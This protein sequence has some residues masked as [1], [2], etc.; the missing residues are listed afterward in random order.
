MI[1][2]QFRL[3]DND[4]DTI[5]ILYYVMKTG[6]KY[7]F[8][9]EDEFREVKVPGETRIPAGT[10][11]IKM[12]KEGGFY[13]RYS[14]RH[15]VKAIREITKK[16]GIPWLQDVPGFKLILI[17]CGNDADDTD[18]CLCT[19]MFPNNNSVKPGFISYSADAYVMLMMD[20]IIPAIE[21]N[22]P[23]Y[24]EITDFDR[25]MLNK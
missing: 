10:Y 11:E 9:I 2:K 8:I 6:M 21:N 22:E 17:H 16:Y 20:A 7:I 24:I 18:G 12:R 23:M 19:G 3:F 5:S 15:K 14:N 25:E 1:L 4:D 13:D